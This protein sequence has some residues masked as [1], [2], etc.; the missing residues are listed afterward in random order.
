MKTMKFHFRHHDHHSSLGGGIIV[1]V[2]KHP[3]SLLVI[4]AH[5]KEQAA[6]DGHGECGAG[7]QRAYAMD[8]SRH[9]GVYI[10]APANSHAKS[11]SSSSSSCS[12]SISD[13]SSSSVVSRHFDSALSSTDSLSVSPPPS[14]ASDDD[15]DSASSPV[16]KRALHLEHHESEC[17]VSNPDP[18]S[19]PRSRQ[20]FR[21][22][23]HKYKAA[24]SKNTIG[25]V[26]SDE[27]RCVG[28]CSDSSDDE[29]MHGEHHRSR[30]GTRGIAGLRKPKLRRAQSLPVVSKPGNDIINPRATS[31]PNATEGAISTEAWINSLEQGPPS[32]PNALAIDERLSQSESA[33]PS[34]HQSHHRRSVTFT[35]VQVREYSTI[36]GDH[37]CCPSGPPL[38]LGWELKRENSTEFETYEKEREPLRCTSREQLRLGGE[39]RREILKSLVVSSPVVA[40]NAG[41]GEET[42]AGSS[43]NA[44]E[45]AEASSKPA[46]ASQCCVYSQQELRRAERRLTRDRQGLNSRSCRRQNRGFFRP[47]SAAECEI[48]GG[49]RVDAVTAAGES[50]MKDGGCGA[51]EECRMDISPIKSASSAA[52]SAVH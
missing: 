36:L 21:L 46:A 20:F 13:N 38:S 5:A 23:R 3:S 2:A 34:L 50:P 41:G 42:T 37:P 16:S 1:P 35:C 18:H 39:E 25:K 47:L 43:T 17:P 6:H 14:P 51:S 12:V 31:S 33:L 4:D 15:D 24:S 22:G 8:A 45:G 11:P 44:D 52:S 49:C 28:L 19:R 26:N 27:T 30:G 48:G 10:H 9:H 29:L 32:S 40:A 7:Q